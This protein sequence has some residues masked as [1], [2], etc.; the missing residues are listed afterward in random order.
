SCKSLTSISIPDGVTSIGDGA[1]KSCDSLANVSIPESVTS[2][3]K[4]AFAECSEL[5]TLTVVRNSWAASWCKENGMN[6]T[7]TDAL[8]WLKQ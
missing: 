1:F 5:L 7:Y 3:S 6:Y 8:D 4:Y 2:I